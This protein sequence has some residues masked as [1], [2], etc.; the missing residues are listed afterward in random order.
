M[1]LDWSEELRYAKF[2]HIGLTAGST[3]NISMPF[4]TYKQWFEYVVPK[5]RHIES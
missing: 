2:W 1:T 5:S 3:T 4:T